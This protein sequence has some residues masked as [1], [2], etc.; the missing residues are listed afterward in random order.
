MPLKIIS[1]NNAL[2]EF[3]FTDISLIEAAKDKKW[4]ILTDEFELKRVFSDELPVIYFS[5]I[6]AND[7]ILN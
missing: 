5:N 3:G 4:V 1:K 7:L 6:V 2:I